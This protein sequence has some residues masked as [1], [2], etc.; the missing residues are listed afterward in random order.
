VNPEF[1]SNDLEEHS[2]KL[3]QEVLGNEESENN[4]QEDEVVEE[5]FEDVLLSGS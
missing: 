4:D 3:N 2:S 5:S 1:K